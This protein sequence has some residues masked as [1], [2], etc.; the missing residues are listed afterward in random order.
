[1]TQ[2]EVAAIGPDQARQI[3]GAVAGDRLETLYALTLALGLRQSEVLGLRWEDID[4]DA[5]TLDVRRTLQRAG[6]EF[7]FFGTK[8]PRSR[9]TLSLAPPLVEQL[10]SHR[11]RQFAERLASSAAWE[12]ERWDDLVFA[13]E[14]GGPLSN[15]LVTSHFQKLLEEA[16]LP[17]MRF[18]DLRHAAATVM[19]TLGVQARVVME[20]LGHSQISTTMDR[21]SH[22]IPE[23]QQDASERVGAAL[24]DAG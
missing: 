24:W 19:L 7:R 12:G 14:V 15:Y 22:V 9:R 13:T 1:M 16:G 17:R 2:E 5:G 21:C 4:L 10:R 18:H 6:G 20:T 8:T 3:L 23:L 11:N